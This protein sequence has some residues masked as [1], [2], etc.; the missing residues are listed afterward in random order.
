MFTTM[1]KLKT[2]NNL[3]KLSSISANS[4]SELNKAAGDRMGLAGIHGG[5]R[6]GRISESVTV[7]ESDTLK[8]AVTC[9]G[10]GRSSRSWLVNVINVSGSGINPVFI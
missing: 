8:V 6:L 2:H 1:R 7:S 4:R 9:S 5:L 3:P 10:S